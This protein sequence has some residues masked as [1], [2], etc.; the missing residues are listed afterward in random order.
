MEKTM[1]LREFFNGVSEYLN[2][3]VTEPTVL[4]SEKN[5]AWQAIIEKQLANIDN[6][7]EKRKAKQAELSESDKLAIDAITETLSNISKGIT[8]AEILNQTEYLDKNRANFSSSKVT[9]L[10]KKIDN[11]NRINKG[12]TKTKYVYIIGEEVEE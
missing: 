6:K 11:V 2:E 3:C 12:G 10:L 1:T 5:Q 7:N 9:S 8:V 4:D